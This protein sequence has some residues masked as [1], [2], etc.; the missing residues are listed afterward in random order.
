LIGLDEQ[1]AEQVPD[2]DVGR[3]DGGGHQRAEIARDLVCCDRRILVRHR[4]AP[5][6]LGAI[7]EHHTAERGDGAGDRFPDR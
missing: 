5:P 2:Q 6:Q 4:Q 7:V 3:A 1:A